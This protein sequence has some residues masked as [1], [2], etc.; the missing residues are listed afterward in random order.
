[1]TRE[2]DAGLETLEVDLPAVVTTDLRLNEP[3]FI[4]LPDIMKAKN[5]PLETIA[6]ADLGVDA[7]ARSRPRTT[8]RRAHA[9]KGVMVKDVA[10]L[11]AA[12]QAARGCCDDRK[13][14]IVA[15]HDDGKLNPRTAKCVTC[16][17]PLRR[18]P[19]TSSC[20]AANAGG[21]AA[22]GGADRRR[23][24]RCSTVANAA[25]AHALAAVLAPQVAALAAGYTHVLGPSTTF[26]KDLMPCV[27]ALLGVAQVSDVMAVEGAHTF[28]R[29]IYAGNAIITVEAPQGTTVVATVR[30]AS[31]RPRRGG[32]SAPVEAASVDATLPTHTRFVELAAGK[33]DRPDLQSATRVVSGGRGARQRRELQDHLQ[34]RRQARRRGRRLARR[35]RRRLRAERPAG[36]PDR[37]DHRAGAVRRHRHLRR[38]PAPDRH[39]GRRHDRRDQQGRRRADLRDRR[40]RPGRRSV[41]DPAGAEKALWK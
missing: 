14:L 10:E 6:L 38:D 2:V 11:V 33:S 25:N 4:K 27:A 36:R 37:Q 19:S 32:G 15:E 29:P 8:R 7:G 1:M 40:H 30:T 39:Q 22:R 3:R 41:Q 31:F 12:L 18:A 9:Q 35:G 23:R 28:K 24:A 20:C 21:V 16:A 34:P 17:Q 13:V 5:K 26:G